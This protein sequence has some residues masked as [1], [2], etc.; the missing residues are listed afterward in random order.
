MKIFNA[1]ILC[2]FAS[3]Q[4]AIA[5]TSTSIL[6]SCT[7]RYSTKSV[8]VVK[9]ITTRRAE[10]FYAFNTFTRPPPTTIT[11]TLPAKQTIYTTTQT[12]VPAAIKARATDP[13][14]LGVDEA[15]KKPR[16]LP[17]G[18]SRGVSLPRIVPNR[19]NFRSLSAKTLYPYVVY[20]VYE[21]R[22]VSI[23]TVTGAQQT[24][25]QTITPR[26]TTKTV[27]ETVTA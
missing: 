14:V 8:S 24:V 7:I 17:D 16:K 3:I 10:Y 9:T 15:S 12:T 18:A 5:D 6:S 21:I 2:L 1:V 4:V 25:K 27:T 26:Y 23:T 22:R 13:V 11:V 20:C 19:F